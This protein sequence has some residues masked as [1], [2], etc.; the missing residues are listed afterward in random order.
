MQEWAKLAKRLQGFLKVGTVNCSSEQK[1][2][3]DKLRLETFPTYILFQRG[4]MTFYEGAN[5][6]P[7]LQEFALTKLGG[8]I[9]SVTSTAELQVFVKMSCPRRASWGWCI[10]LITKQKKPSALY[11]A[12]SEQFA[13]KLAFLM[14]TQL[15]RLR[16]SWAAPWVQVWDW[17]NARN[18][19]DRAK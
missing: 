15:T 7:E 18:A 11:R 13:G 1:L 3:F 2:C 8:K 6:I 5:S 10:V 17:T 9:D 14:F 19:R 12:L 4:K 16:F